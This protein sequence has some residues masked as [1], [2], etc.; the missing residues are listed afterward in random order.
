MMD[1]LRRFI[2]ALFSS[3]LL[4]LGACGG[5]GG[6]GGGDGTPPPNN[7]PALQSVSVSPA[8]ASIIQGAAHSFPFTATARY[9]DGSTSD[10]TSQATWDSS[11]K[12]H[13]TISAAGIA[14][15][16]AAGSTEI[17]ATFG[18]RTGTATL[19][20]T[21][22]RQ[23]AGISL[24]PQ[25]TTVSVGDTATFTVT[26]NGTSPLTYQWRKNGENVGTNSPIHV[27]PPTTMADNGARFDVIVNNAYGGATSTEAVLTVIPVV[28]IAYLHHSTGGN[29]WSG[30]I[31]D[32][33]NAY[34]A[35]QNKNYRI[36]SITYP[37]TTNGYPWANYP[38]DYWNLWIN[39]TG[40]S[41]DRGEL[42]LDQLAASYDVIVFK[43]CFPVSDI[44]S[45]ASDESAPSPVQTV[46]NY[47][48]LYNALKT[49]MLAF[50]T[51]KFIVWTGAALIEAATTAEKATRAKTFFD[52]VKS[53]WDTPGDNIFL[54]DFFA[55]ETGNAA[56]GYMNSSYSTA[57]TNNPYDS[58]PNSNFS[59]AVAPFMPQRI[60]DVIEGR[61]D[62]GSITGQ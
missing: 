51:K 46:H 29:I 44:L 50:P 53:D 1:H 11:N 54:W 23:P 45:E 12:A 21:A 43:H 41:Q 31:P 24:A 19:T 62:S 27:T 47:Q 57:N 59:S 18:G 36:T 33:I 17:S 61:G 10:V 40:A 6:G 38:Y 26:G 16:V 4:L 5:G 48:L 37:A 49:R 35:S 20:V 34:N 15:G 56:S 52:W 9:S 60:I 28:R 8:T 39:H 42:N 13:A 2:A 58:H 25:N 55:L 30:G 3:S 22:D 7:P 14:T 32:Y